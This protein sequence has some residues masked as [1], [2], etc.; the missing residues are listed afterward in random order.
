ML[1]SHGHHGAIVS[2]TL[3]GAIGFGLLGCATRCTPRPELPFEPSRPK[4]SFRADDSGLDISWQDNSDNEK[5]FKVYRK[6]LDAWRLVEVLP[7]NVTH[8][9]E[10][11]QIRVGETY[12]Y[13]ICSYN[14]AGEST[15]LPIS[16]TRKK[17]CDTDSESC[18]ELLAA[19]SAE[20][21]AI[22]SC[23]RDDECGQDLPGTSCGCTRNLVARIDADATCYQ[24]L[25]Q[26]ARDLQCDLPVTVCDCPA[27]DGFVCREGWC[28]W[29]YVGSRP[30]PAS[31][32]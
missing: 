32:Q 26:R 1:R 4:I 5:G 2:K 13:Q 9:G 24:D 17:S 6:I 18:D 20:G 14:E 16:I 12:W 28:S 31:E 27:A 30:G 21:E 10:D 7:E 22:R 25:R 19:L 11:E 3:V 8:F 15:R 23:T 29:N